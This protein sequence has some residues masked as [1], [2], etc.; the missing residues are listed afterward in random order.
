MK[1]IVEIALQ[2][3]I[4]KEFLDEYLQVVT[5]MFLMFHFVESVHKCEVVDEREYLV[6]YNEKYCKTVMARDAEH[7][8]SL[9][10][11]HRKGEILYFNTE[12][13]S[14]EEKR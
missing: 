9:V 3:D 5:K 13:V 1:A 2:D 14:V 11:D 8:R 6:D 10:I 7:A 12:T 4:D